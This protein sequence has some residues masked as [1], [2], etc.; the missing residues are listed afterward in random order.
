VYRETV[1]P[2][3]MKKLENYRVEVVLGRV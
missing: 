3:E 1:A 2:N